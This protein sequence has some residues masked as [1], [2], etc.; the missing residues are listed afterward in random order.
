MNTQTFAQAG[1]AYGRPTPARERL[2]MLFDQD[3]FV[4]ID[5]FSSVEGQPCGVVC[6]YGAVNGS[7]ACAFAQEGGGFGRAQADK[8]AKLYDLALKTG[9]PVVGIYDSNGAR[10]SEGVAALEAYG[11]LLLRIN[12][13]SGVLPQIAL[14]AGNC[15]GASAMLACSADLVIMT[16]QARFFMT[17]PALAQDN[18]PDAGGG[19]N[20][21]KSGVAH[22]LADTPQDACGYARKLLSYLPINNLATSPAL[23]YTEPQGV[24]APGNYQDA[25]PAALAASIF[26]EGSLIPLLGDFGGSVYTALGSLGGI[27]V[28]VAGTK[29]KLEADGCA[30]LAKVVSVCDAFQIPVV[31]LVNT[32]GF[33]PSAKAELCG[34]IREMAKLGHVYAEATTPKACVITGKAYGAAYVAL[35]SRASNSD[36]TVAWPETVISALEPAAAVELLHADEISA[37]RSRDAILR[38]YLADVASPLAAAKAG[39]LDDVISPELTRAALLSALDLLSAKRVQKNPKKH[40]NLPM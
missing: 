2:G 11:E 29:G 1:E 25:D 39:Y 32:D 14:V 34:S 35:A 40:S 17:P 33:S 12:N 4:E 38:D 10:V 27:P 24:L 13:L 6:G 18:A 5:R 15:T 3:S 30:K 37:A 7:P 23:A 16:G 21:A 31:T 36:Y 8:I 28:G 19:Q 9:V 22:I 20:A 26:D